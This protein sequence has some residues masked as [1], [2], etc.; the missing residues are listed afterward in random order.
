LSNAV[1]NNELSPFVAANRLLDKY[2][3]N[4]NP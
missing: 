2:F 4:I 1:K 3:K